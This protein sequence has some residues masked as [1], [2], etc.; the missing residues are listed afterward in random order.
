MAVV[1]L[2]EVLG[3]LDDRNAGHADHHRVRASVQGRG[4]RDAVV[5][6]VEGT[7]RILLAADH[8]HGTCKHQTHPSG[9]A[10]ERRPKSPADH[11]G[12]NC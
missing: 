1:T 10:E 12:T 4:R 2:S 8:C 6:V 5:D 11:M 7:G 3:V 9:T